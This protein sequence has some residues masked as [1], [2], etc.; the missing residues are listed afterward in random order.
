[1]DKPLQVG[2]GL[3]NRETALRRRELVPEHVER[4]LVRG[5]RFGG[6]GGNV[7][8]QPGPVV[9]DQL[10]QQSGDSPAE[11]FH[12]A[13]ALYKL[14]KDAIRDGK[15]VGIASTPDCLETRFVGL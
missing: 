10:M 13:L 7:I 15:D 11:L 9:L 2:Q 6:E 12:K 5:A 4:D 1:M 3:G 14:A 8:V